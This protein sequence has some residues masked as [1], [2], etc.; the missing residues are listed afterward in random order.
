[1]A[2]KTVSVNSE[3]VITIRAK[4]YTTSVFCSLG[5]ELQEW[6]KCEQQYPDDGMKTKHGGWIVVICDEGDHA[7]FVDRQVAP[8][9][10]VND[11]ALL[12]P[13]QYAPCE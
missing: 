13:L 11:A 7:F 8:R 1:M 12:F 4:L 5:S 10:H 2:C 6:I 3:R 9:T